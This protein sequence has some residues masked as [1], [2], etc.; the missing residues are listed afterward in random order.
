[1]PKP[2]RKIVQ[3]ATYHCFSRCQGLNKLLLNK[4]AKTAFI[5]AVKMCQ[6]YY[7]FE[8]SAAEMVD[9]HTHLAIKTLENGGTID[10]IMQYIKARTAEK[11]NRATGRKGP[12]WNERYKCT[13]IEESEYP[14]EYLYK[15]LWYVGYNPVKKGLSRD[16]RENYIGFINCYLIENYEVS[17]IKIT[18]HHFF[19]RL[20]NTFSECVKKFLLY[21]DA[22]LKGLSLSF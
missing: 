22:Y 1:M 3:G 8:L 14:Q 18:L 20:G 4:Y 19:Y 16:P 15:L 2:L 13:I 10:R 7:E 11:F 6:D 21:E 12:F 5:E 9:N 17:S